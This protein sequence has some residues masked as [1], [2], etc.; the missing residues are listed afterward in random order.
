MRAGMATDF[1]LKVFFFPFANCSLAG[2]N[3]PTSLPGTLQRQAQE[4]RR[5]TVPSFMPGK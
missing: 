1:E 5:N 2:I 3:P 4:R